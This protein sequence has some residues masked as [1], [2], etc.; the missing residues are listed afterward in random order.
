MQLKDKKDEVE[1]MTFNLNYERWYQLYF[2][3]SVAALGSSEGSEGG[4]LAEEEVEIPI[5]D[6]DELDAFYESREK[7]KWMS[8]GDIPDPFVSGE[9]TGMGVGRRV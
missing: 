2:P 8:V 9:I 6:I 7:T 3:N 1:L 5:T 4:T